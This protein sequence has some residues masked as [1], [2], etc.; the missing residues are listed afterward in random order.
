MVAL[1]AGCGSSSSSS[2]TGASTGTAS[3]A[4]STTSGSVETTPAPPSSSSQVDTCLEG[5]KRLPSL[6]ADTRARLESICRKGGN[7]NSE[8]ARKAAVEAC[9]ELVKAS[10]LPAGSAK[11]KAL[12]TCKHAGGSKGG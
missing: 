7:G 5:V 12:A 2:S 11:D 8:E 10:P 1:L 3:T 6:K 9:E 4:P